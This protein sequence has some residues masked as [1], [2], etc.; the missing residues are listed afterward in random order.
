MICYLITEDLCIH[1]FTDFFSQAPYDE[2]LEK[3]IPGTLAL[4]FAPALFQRQ[5]VLNIGYSASF[6]VDPIYI[7]MVSL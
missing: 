6:S 2:R 3:S 5:Y 4:F 1:Q 7:S